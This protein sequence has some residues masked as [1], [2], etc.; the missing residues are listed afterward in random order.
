MWRKGNPS[1]LLVGMQPLWET[2]WNFLRKLK[3]EL[4][5]DPA[6]LLLGLYPKNPETPIQKNL[7]TPMFIAAQFTIAKYWEQPRCPSAN[8]WIQKLW[9]IYTMEFYT[10]ERKKELIPFIYF[11]YRKIFI[12][13]LILNDSLAGYSNLGCRSLLF[14]T[15]HLQISVEKSGD[16]LMGIS[17]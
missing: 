17:L 7:C 12:P 9:Y 11:L 4:P 14:I 16:S 8:E 3:M 15:T 10:A 2:V 13:A 6:I 1:A 5:F